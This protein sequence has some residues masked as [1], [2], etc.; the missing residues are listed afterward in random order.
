MEKATKPGDGFVAFL[1]HK[2]EKA[3][4]SGLPFDFF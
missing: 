1:L 4:R 2:I 3:D